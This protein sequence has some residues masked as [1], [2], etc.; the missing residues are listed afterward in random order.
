MRYVKK[1]FIGISIYLF[2]IL[3]G[4]TSNDRLNLGTLQSFI[5]SHS[6]QSKKPKTQIAKICYNY[7]IFKRDKVYEIL[8][9][10]NLLKEAFRQTGKNIF[11]NVGIWQSSINV[12]YLWQRRC[13]ILGK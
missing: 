11:Y 10:E 13:L 4:C 2:F 12:I 5:P 8:T 3:C 7:S 1:F 9:L 6:P